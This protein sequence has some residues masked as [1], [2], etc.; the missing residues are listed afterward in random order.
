MDPILVQEAKELAEIKAFFAVARNGS[1]ISNNIT[2]DLYH[3]GYKCGCG[4][5]VVRYKRQFCSQ[6]VSL[7]AR[8]LSSVRNQEGPLVGGCF[9]VLR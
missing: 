7:G 8:S 3:I 2:N 4:F 1:M 5:L 9:C 6:L